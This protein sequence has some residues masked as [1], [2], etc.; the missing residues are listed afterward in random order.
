MRWS[1]AARIPVGIMDTGSPELVVFSSGCTTCGDASAYNESRSASFVRGRRRDEHVYG[2]GGCQTQDGQDTVALGPLV[3]ERQ[4]LWM[5]E[6]CS[7]PL[8][9]HASFS[10]IVGMGPPGQKEHMAR[11]N[12]EDLRKASESYSDRG[13]GVPSYIRD[14]EQRWRDRLSS[15]QESPSL[16]EHLGLSTFSVCYGRE[17]GSPG[18]IRWNDTKAEVGFPMASAPVLGD[19]AWEVSLEKVGLGG[20]GI[21]LQTLGCE[22]CTATLDTGTSLIGM[23]TNVI[24]RLQELL[25]GLDLDCSDLSLFPDLVMS[26]GSND[27]RLPPDAY[28]GTFFG[29]MTTEMRQILHTDDLGGRGSVQCQLLLMDLGDDL[30]S[31]D[32]HFI[33]GTP[34]FREYYTMFNIG[35]GSGDRSVLFT[36]ADENCRPVQQARSQAS[37]GLTFHRPRTPVVA[38]QVDVSR[39]RLPERLRGR[40]GM[41]S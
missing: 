34:F 27:V 25:V 28:V 6:S 26:I 38:R 24:T 30:T 1:A 33:L 32:P 37:P 9:L 4:Q 5:A 23:P 41:G 17:S 7:M 12:L 8:L 39:L 13:H 22:E 40:R 19:L 35:T 29:D 36:P 18:W 16:I 11:R 14:S 31:T 2:S 20:Q 3:A 10:A 15:A 21:A